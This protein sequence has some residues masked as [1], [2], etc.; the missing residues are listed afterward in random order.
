MTRCVA[1]DPNPRLSLSVQPCAR[2]PV[3]L[4]VAAPLGVLMTT[5]L[6]E[7]V[8]PHYFPFAL[9]LGM[10]SG[11]GCCCTATSGCWF[12]PPIVPGRAASAGSLRRS[13]PIW[14]LRSNSFLA[15]LDELVG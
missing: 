13:N 7:C 11:T 8:H 15:R 2:G 4:S 1:G 5:L 6:P 14:F 10:S 3:V 9:M 12:S